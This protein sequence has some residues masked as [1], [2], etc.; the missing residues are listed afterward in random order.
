M[1]SNRLLF[2]YC[3]RFNTWAQTADP[4]F[5]LHRKQIYTFFNENKLAIDFMNQNIERQ[6]KEYFIYDGEVMKMANGSGIFKDETMKDKY[7]KE[8]NAIFDK[9]VKITINGYTI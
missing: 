5:Y 7:A 4:E 2:A 1:G 6:N 8:L 9:P 3:Q